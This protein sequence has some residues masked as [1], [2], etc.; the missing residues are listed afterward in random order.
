M[1]LL[2]ADDKIKT[3]AKIK[4]TNVQLLRTL[5]H[6]SVLLSAGRTLLTVTGAGYNKNCNLKEQIKKGKSSFYKKEKIHFISRT[7]FF[8]DP[9]TL[10]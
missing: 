1:P 7:K 4:P 6:N 8:A 5:K 9:L 3:R 10:L 2:E